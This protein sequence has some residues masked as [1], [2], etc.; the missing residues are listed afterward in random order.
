MTN[1]R[2]L[3]C[4][5]LTKYGND[6]LKAQPAF[7]RALKKN[8]KLRKVLEIDYLSEIAKGHALVEIHHAAP[9]QDGSHQATD[10]QTTSAAIHQF[11]ESTGAGEDHVQYDNQISDV[12]SAQAKEGGGHGRFD[13]QISNAATP[14]KNP[15]DDRTVP[16]KGYKVKPFYRYPE[17]TEAEKEVTRITKLTSSS[18][19]QRFGMEKLRY[20]ELDAFIRENAQTGNARIWQGINNVQR[21]ALASLIRRHATPPDSSMLVRDI[22]S[23]ADLTRL[24]AVAI[25]R[26]PKLVTSLID[27]GTKQ[28]AREVEKIAAE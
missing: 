26:A 24:E 16:V 25:A 6:P 10:N 28:L 7:D 21:A 5:L 18:V 11:N 27:R 14:P 1:L 3:A 20:H 12:S 15:D 4:D 8:L 9:L 13:T 19:L 2:E 17:R 22:I 23:D